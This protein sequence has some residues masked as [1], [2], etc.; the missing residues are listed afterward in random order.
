MPSLRLVAADT[1]LTM[2]PRQVVCCPDLGLWLTP[3]GG[4]FRIDL[5]RP[6]YGPWQATQVDAESGAALRS[7]PARSIAGLR[8]L[9]DFLTV[10]FLDA[11]G[12]T[13]A[14]RT[15]TFCPGGFDGMERFRDDGPP[16]PGFSGA[17]SRGFP[18][19]VG[20]VWGLSRG[21]AEQIVIEGSEFA[22][23]IPRRILGRLPARLRERLR[24]L[25]RRQPGAIRLEP[26]MYRM[27]A[28]IN[29]PHRRVFGIPAEDAAVTLRIRV[30]RAKRRGREAGPASATR[31]SAVRPLAAQTLEA[32]PAMTRPDLAALPPWA[33]R[34]RHKKR[35]DRDILTFASSPWN[36][37]PA[38]LVVEGFRRSG[39]GDMEAYQY[40]FDADGEVVGR[41]PA[42]A[43]AFHDAPRHH[44][45]HFLQMV[46]Y[47][48][49]RPGGRTVV[50]SRKQSFCITSTDP[51]DLTLPRALVSPGPTT[52]GGSSCGSPG[53]IWIRQALPAGWADTYGAGIPGQSVDI[54]GVPNGRYL[55]EMHVNPERELFEVSTDNNIASRRLTLS[56]KPGE[57]RVRV[58]PW[59]GIRG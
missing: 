26:G 6:G 34:T 7:I 8:G 58:A 28:R 57:R 33:L 51:V 50:R 4:D 46:T 49:L 39:G 25:A 22:G 19:T 17:C 15:L 14:S 42:G 2:T 59:R 21:W 18:F 16:L 13:V 52:I 48:L 5:K 9:K 11:R 53:S 38:P 44:H 32:P 36:A 41:A 30:V 20:M 3:T 35:R 43:M 23:E 55:I 54:T 24:R 27:V 56:G 10:R 1:S 12:R 37:G 45:W 47:R 40:F 31:A 29:A